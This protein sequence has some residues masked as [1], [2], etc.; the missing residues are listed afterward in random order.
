MDEFPMP[1]PLRIAC[2]GL[3]HDHVWSN[4]EE[5]AHITGAELVGAADPNPPLLEKVAGLYGCPTF[6]DYDELLDT[7]TPDAVYVFAGNRTGASLT[8]A[9][10]ERGLH[11]FVE[12]PMA[13]DLAGAE[14][15][16]AAAESRDLRLMINWPF[17]WWPAL[18]EAIRRA[19]QGDIGRLWQV[20]YRAAH[21]GPRELGCSDY[22]CDWLYDE[23]ENGAGALM[24]YCCYG[25]VLARVLL[26]LPESVSGTKAR[27]VKNDIAVDDNAILVMHYPDALATTEASWTQIGNLTAYNTTLYGEAGTILVEPPG[28]VQPGGKLIL[29]TADD[30]SGTEQSI[31]EPGPT[32]RN[33]SAH[34]IHL[35]QKPDA[36]IHPLCAP[37][38]CRDGQAIL[39]AGL[40]AT[41]SGNREQISPSAASH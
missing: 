3:H 21:Q 22:F 12:K 36:N 27:L 9:A 41:N 10:L 32:S 39:Q 8:T 15:M 23:Q 11:A 20:R 26:G 1:P 29:A 17:A 6:A 5:L 24:D 33:G 37:Q 14:A 38:A 13:A 4:L 25:T 31:P 18:Q 16:L 34:F 19:N 30:Q 35:L 28:E 2:L 40:T 7:T